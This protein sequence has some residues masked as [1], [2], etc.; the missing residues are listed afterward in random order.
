MAEPTQFTFNWHEVT[1]AL[2]KQQNL[3]EG[4]WV[5][6]LEFGLGAGLFAQAPEGH[7]LVP[8]A[9]LAVQKVQLTK[10][11]ENLPVHSLVVDAAEVNPSASG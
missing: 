2:I 4:R 7:E 1:K 3:H 6:G 8:G 10:H 9:M 5:L 11:P